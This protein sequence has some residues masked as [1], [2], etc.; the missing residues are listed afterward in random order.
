MR[1]VV[2]FDCRNLLSDFGNLG[3]EGLAKQTRKRC[4]KMKGIIAETLQLVLV[5]VLQELEF[6][7]CG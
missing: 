4:I 2:S 3:S 5:R 7:S 6:T 1:C